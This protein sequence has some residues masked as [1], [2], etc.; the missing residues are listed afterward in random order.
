[1]HVPRELGGALV[2]GNGG[3]YARLLEIGFELSVAI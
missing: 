2:T 3:H 1:M